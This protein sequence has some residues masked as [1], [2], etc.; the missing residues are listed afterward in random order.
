LSD[1]VCLSLPF[2]RSCGS[3]AT[4]LLQ[5]IAN[6][7][8]TLVPLFPSQSHLHHYRARPVDLALVD[9]L[10]TWRQLELSGKKETKKMPASDC[11]VGEFVRC[12]L[13]WWLMW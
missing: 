7:E 10:P 1:S 9:Y 8:V 13:D 6:S 3:I 2:P 11:P 12:L 5:S 4:A